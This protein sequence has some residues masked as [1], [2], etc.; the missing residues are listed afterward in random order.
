MKNLQ[1]YDDFLSES[2][3]LTYRDLEPSLRDEFMKTDIA[4]KCY[5]SELTI[6]GS[7]WGL[8]HPNGSISI[9]FWLMTDDIDIK[10][11]DKIAKKWGDKNALITSTFYKNG[12]AS[13]ANAIETQNWRN[14]AAMNAKF[15]YGYKFYKIPDFFGKIY[16]QL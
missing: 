7:T 9:T 6:S 15:I 16:K 8:Y 13:N 1:T 12:I 4:K 14:K 10:K 3:E 2:K 11:L 5:N